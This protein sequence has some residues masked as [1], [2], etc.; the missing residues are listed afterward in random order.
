[1]ETKFVEFDSLFI[2][3]AL[4]QKLVSPDQM[5]ECLQVQRREADSGRK[6]SI[7]Q[8]LIKRRYISC[9]DFLNI[10]NN[11]E[12]K[13]Y[14]CNTCK[15]RYRARELK[16]GAITCRGCGQMVGIMGPQNFAQAEILATNNPDALT[17]SMD[18]VNDGG[19]EGSAGAKGASPAG[20]AQEVVSSTKPSNGK[21]STAPRWGAPRIASGSGSNV[22]VAAPV[23]APVNPIPS[24]G[25]N[26]AAK[27][28]NGQKKPT[29][30]Y[31]PALDFSQESLNALDRYE[32]L[33][34][35][36]R[37]GMGIVFKAFQPDMDRVCALKVITTSPSVSPSQINRF[38]Q[39]GRSA[40]QLH[41]PN[42]IRIF[43]CGQQRNFFYIAMEFLEGK[44]LNEYM[45][46]AKPEMEEIL[47]LFDELLD[48]VE[49]AHQHGVVHRDLKPQNIMIETHTSRTKLID[50]GLAK[51]FTHGMDLTQPGQIL[52]SPFYLSPE[53]TRGE[54]YKVDGR[55]DVF[56]LGV[57]L[58]ELTTGSRPF[59]GKSAPEVYAKILN[60]RPPPPMALNPEIDQD[61]QD[62]IL[63]A[64]E[65]DLDERF[66]SAQEMKDAL[67]GYRDF[68]KGRSPS[69]KQREEPR[70][71]R[72]RRRQTANN[73]SQ[74]IRK[75]LLP[76]R[77]SQRFS[78]ARARA[79]GKGQSSGNYDR[80]RVRDR[81]RG[82]TGRVAT[83]QSS[84]ST[85]VWI[86]LVLVIIAGVLITAALF[87]KP[88]R[89]PIKDPDSTNDPAPISITKKGDD[90]NSKSGKSGEARTDAG[91]NNKP[92]SSTLDERAAT[93]LAEIQ[94]IFDE[95]GRDYGDTLYRLKIFTQKYAD[96]KVN[97][98]AIEFKAR[99]FKE[100]NT[101]YAKVKKKAFELGLQKDISGA[102]TLIDEL[103]GRV[104][105]TSW[106]KKLEQL[107]GQVS[108]DFQTRI[109]GMI[110]KARGFYEA[111]KY[112]EARAILDELY[113]S[114]NEAFDKTIKA[115]AQRI[116]EN[117]K[118]NA[119]NEVD[120]R[121]KL[122]ARAVQIRDG[123]KEL[124]KKDKFAEAV[125]LIDQL[126]G[127]RFDAKLVKEIK[128][129]LDEG[130][131]LAQ[132]MSIIKGLGDKVKGLKIAIP[133]FKG[134]ISDA[135]G[136]KI[137]IAGT[138]GGGSVYKLINKLS[139]SNLLKLFS[140]S[141][142][143]E[144]AEG[145]V[146]QGVFALHRKLYSKALD[147][148]TEGKKHG[149]KKDPYFNSYLA[150]A[151][152]K[153]TS[154]RRKVKPT[155]KSGKRNVPSAST[156][157]ILTKDLFAPVSAGPFLMGTNNGFS[158]CFPQRSIT[159]G[160]YKVMKYEVSVA[161][162]KA[163]LAAVAKLPANKRHKHCH[164]NEGAEKDHA[165]NNWTEPAYA[166]LFKDNLP[167]TQVDWYD[168]YSFARFHNCRLPTEAE[169]E[170]AAR[171]TD[172]R[173]YP[174]GE[175]WDRKRAVSIPYWLDQD[176]A[177]QRSNNELNIFINAFRQKYLGKTVTLAVKE[178]PNG[179][180]VYGAYN[181]IGNVEEWCMDI[182]SA[183]IYSAPGNTTNPEGPALGSTRSVR[184]GNFFEAR[185]NRFHSYFRKEYKPT[186]RRA[187]LGFRVIK[188]KHGY[189]LH[190]RKK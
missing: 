121:K 107:K 168:A 128:L 23:P 164:P 104:N 112:D 21:I 148:L 133:G 167:I 91:N 42:I 41:H 160:H 187:E 182:Y 76:S 15:T 7:G 162:Y 20:Q 172:G 33:E 179:R 55:S 178:L 109:E 120:E 78:T 142:L 122:L 56:A 36:G 52:G 89:V 188:P 150:R 125:A 51:D 26:A 138:K 77:S 115:L 3:N 79:I 181:M 82:A 57:I 71:R 50:F 174:W 13:V 83:R 1:M 157:A 81:D 126:K 132:F 185:P 183:D 53:Q 80:R 70:I 22:G 123:A 37:G 99:V 118:K 169:W 88:P 147:L 144:K 177:N 6:Y 44:P 105:E 90:K 158:H 129:I 163:F 46:E 140:R 95:D 39:E 189:K 62:I 141:D 49:Y 25:P 93:A 146:L 48:A 152:A 58:Y 103:L 24:A 2:K 151:E 119:S 139:T 32:I 84:D 134:K 127:S 31:R 86:L 165:P 149:A 59:T 4:H 111:G 114:K 17:I 175:Q 14:E 45:K 97:S 166:H 137:T 130:R 35:L 116:S 29:A 18:P 69:P 68:L 145:F 143:A 102:E 161:Q 28:P 190:N 63:D 92:P 98:A 61:L 113:P 43:D 8:I 101:E 156:K 135:D 9:T 10:Q 54:S 11:L 72:D 176:M 12:R 27:G 19:P 170:K 108:R 85:K 100:G 155:T 65:K 40:A 67:V 159:V 87:S 173:A 180:S 106:H 75:N 47:R 136:E 153:A 16:N 73:S 34:E 30:R 124:I 64:L 131:K 96:S 66:Q 110:E 60:S 117:E 38:V 184:G 74:R 186:T 154:T 5:E 171:G 94:S